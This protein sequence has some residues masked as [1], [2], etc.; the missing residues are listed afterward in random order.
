MAEV[1]KRVR[2]E[3]TIKLIQLLEQIK[4]DTTREFTKQKLME[5]L[6]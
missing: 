4:T 6:Q 1:E 5:D 2:K 3:G